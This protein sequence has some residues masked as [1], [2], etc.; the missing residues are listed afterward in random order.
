MMLFKKQTKTQKRI[1][2]KFLNNVALGL[3]S[4]SPVPHLSLSCLLF[5]QVTEIDLTLIVS[6]ASDPSKQGTIGDVT[7]A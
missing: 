6:L 2:N 1:A 7:P 5:L 3:I 4:I